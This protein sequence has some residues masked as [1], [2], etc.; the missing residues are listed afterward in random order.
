MDLRVQ[1]NKNYPPM[2]A[3]IPPNSTVLDL[4]CG[5]GNPFKGK[6]FPL[7]VGVDVFRKRFHMPEYDVVLCYDLRKVTNLFYKKSFDVV[8]AFDV[9]EHL[10]REEGFK[11]IK[12]AEKIARSKT[13]FFTPTKWT[14]NKEAVENPKYWSYGNQANYHKSL[15]VQKDFIEKG[16]AIK[17]CQEEYV[18]AEKVF[19]I[20]R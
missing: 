5:C 1:D 18:L 14:E 4:G 12:D 3:L 2:I 8:T 7:L 9:I 13:I 16:Y 20:T 10:T 11:L 19:E 17:P 6:K 15:W